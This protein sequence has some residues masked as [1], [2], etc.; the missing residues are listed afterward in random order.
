[1]LCFGFL[2]LTGTNPCPS[3]TSRAMPS[4]APLAPH[5]ML[6]SKPATS[7]VA[8]SAPLG[9]CT[10]AVAL[11][12]S[13]PM[14]QA[15]V[16]WLNLLGT[17]PAGSNGL[18]QTLANAWTLPAT[19][20]E[21]MHLKAI[22]QLAEG[23]CRA[24]GRKVENLSIRWPHGTLALQA[25]HQID[26]FTGHL[27]VLRDRIARALRHWQSGRPARHAVLGMLAFGL[28][29]MG[30]Y[31]QAERLGRQAVA[32]ERRDWPLALASNYAFNVMHAMTA[33]VGAGREHHAI[34]LLRVQ[35]MLRRRR[36][37]PASCAMLA[38]M[39]RRP[40]LISVEASLTSGSSACVACAAMYIASADRNFS[41]KR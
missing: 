5:S 35:R 38:S 21:A 7:F 20:R 17:D 11:S 29:E 27:R 10:H 26:F 8:S 40:S 41:R 28:E 33:Y 32:L 23:H 22:N 14:A 16:A 12:P 13:M 31:G 9:A 37:T 6:P 3:P 34:R 2:E 18:G 30:D 36:T 25:G 1:M 24:A 15:L 4:V 39:P 19:E